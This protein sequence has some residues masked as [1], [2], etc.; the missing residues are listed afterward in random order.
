LGDFIH[1]SREKK[2]GSSNI[3][4]ERQCREKIKT[5]GKLSELKTVKTDFFERD[6]TPEIPGWR[7]F[8]NP[9]YRIENHNILIELNI[10]DNKIKDRIRKAQGSLSNEEWSSNRKKGKIGKAQM[11]NGLNKG[12]EQNYNFKTSPFIAQMSLKRT[13]LSFVCSFGK[14]YESR[15]HRGSDH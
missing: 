12:I 1:D 15:R 8:P 10:E 13:S 3:Y 4:T 7:R 5:F 9:S 11:F 14:A 2:I 6:D